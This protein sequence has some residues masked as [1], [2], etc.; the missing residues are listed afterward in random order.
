V[1]WPIASSPSLSRA[2]PPYAEE[3][4][5]PRGGQIIDFGPLSPAWASFRP[6][7]PD[8]F[9]IWRAPRCRRSRKHRVFSSHRRR[10]FGGADS[11][12]IAGPCSRSV[13]PQ[14]LVRGQD[15]L[16]G[17]A[18]RTV[19]FF[20]IPGIYLAGLIDPSTLGDHL[21]QR[22]RLPS[23]PVVAATAALQQFEESR[24]PVASAATIPPDSWTRWHSVASRSRE[25]VCGADRRSPRSRALQSR[26]HVRGDGRTR[27]FHCQ[28]GERSR[29]AEPAQWRWNDSVLIGGAFVVAAIPTILR[30]R[31][32]A[33]GGLDLSRWAA[34]DRSQRS[35]PMPSAHLRH[36]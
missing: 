1:T 19:A 12:R 30:F 28:S 10:A 4:P 29:P 3:T 26:P 24:R 17:A 32:P 9:A 14:R 20:V 2:P 36:G 35:G 22:L 7:I 25:G 6:A 31:N 15:P 18:A 21:A 23:R 16:T 34:T 13:F 5:L 33:I 8:R 11:A 27:V